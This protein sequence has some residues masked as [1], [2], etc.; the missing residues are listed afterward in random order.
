MTTDII[1]FPSERNKQ[2]ELL[3]KQRINSKEKEKLGPKPLGS[4]Y[5]TIH[6]SM[7]SPQSPSLRECN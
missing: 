6:K 3:N 5:R 2:I 1:L 7:S 4:D